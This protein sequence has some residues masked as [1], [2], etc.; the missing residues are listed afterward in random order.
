VRKPEELDSTDDGR[1]VG[2]S[3]AGTERADA[4]SGTTQTSREGEPRRGGD[5]ESDKVGRKAAGRAEWRMG[6]DN[7]SFDD[8]CAY[9]SLVFSSALDTSDVAPSDA[10]G[11]RK[12]SVG[13][14]RASV[15][16]DERSRLAGTAGTTYGGPRPT[17]G[18]QPAAVTPAGS[19]GA[20]S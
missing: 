6:V 13:G 12:D 9:L 3:R 20:V 15:A 7:S 16:A 17:H 2:E 10:G 1:L 4:V 14:R 19:I 18:S 5:A 8:D 11:P